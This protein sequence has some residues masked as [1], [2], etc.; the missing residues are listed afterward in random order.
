MV[1]AADYQAAFPFAREV[2]GGGLFEGIGQ[3][4]KGRKGRKGQALPDVG[5]EHLARRNGGEEE[6]VKGAGVTDQ[7]ALAIGAEAVQ[8]DYERG[9]GGIYCSGGRRGRVWTLWTGTAP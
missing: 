9:E 5:D 4:Q 8:G 1:R 6:A 3:G 7:Q 2:D